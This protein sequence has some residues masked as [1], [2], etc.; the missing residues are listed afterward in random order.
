MKKVICIV[1]AAVCVIGMLSAC[2]TLKKDDK[3]AIVTMYLANQIYNFD[4]IVGYNDTATAK[5]LS[6]AFEGLTVVDVDGDWH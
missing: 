3:G 5:I 2:S 4:P 1:L 6:L